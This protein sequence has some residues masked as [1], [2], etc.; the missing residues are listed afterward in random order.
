[1]KTRTLG[2]KFTV[3]EVGYGCMGLSG[4]YGPASDDASIAL[5]RKIVEMGVTLLDSADA[6]GNGHNEELLGK[7]LAGIRSKVFLITKFGQQRKPEGTTICGTPQYVHEACNAS[8]KRLKVDAID[9]YFQHRVD[10]SVPIEDTVGAMADLV[11]RGKVR[12]I[13]LSEISVAN[14]RRAHKVHPIAAVQSELSL[15]SRQDETDILP[16]C[17]EL[18]IGYVAYSPLGRGFLTGTVTGRESLDPKDTRQSHPRFA[19]E[20][21]GE[22][23]KLAE[24][25]KALATQKGVTAAQL[26]L[27]WVLHKGQDIIPI[28]GTKSE[29]RVRENIRAAEIVLSAAEIRSLEEIAPIGATKG[30]RYPAANLTHIDR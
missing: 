21:I 19:K 13:G 2:G 9:L 30:E 5:I 17:R 18:G 12:Y 14:L 26:A 25:L 3:P 23:L 28:P 29:A 4:I 7:A 27:A 15:W 24:K 1:M 6:Y 20:N 22:N 8:L 11:K 16:T 10:K